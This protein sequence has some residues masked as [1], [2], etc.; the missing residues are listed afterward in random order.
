MQEVIIGD[1][2]PKLSSVFFDSCATITNVTFLGRPPVVVEA[3]YMGSGLKS[4]LITTTV[5]KDYLKATNSAGRCW[6]DYANGRVIWPAK[7]TWAAEYVASGID[8]KN[9]PLLCPDG[10]LP[11]LMMIVR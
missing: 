6:K 10:S 7:S 9:R 1:A 5:Y 4:T 2:V 8:L 11:G 3:P